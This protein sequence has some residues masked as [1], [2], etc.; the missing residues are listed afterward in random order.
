MYSL[1]SKIIQQLSR[2]IIFFDSIRF[3][4]LESFLERERRVLHIEP[5]I[6]D[7]NF[8]ICSTSIHILRTDGTTK[9]VL[10]RSYGSV[11]SSINGFVQ[12][13]TGVLIYPLW[14]AIVK[15]NRILPRGNIIIGSVTTP[16]FRDGVGTEARFWFPHSMIKI[17]E[18]D[19]ILVSD[20]KNNAIRKVD[21]VTLSVTTYLQHNS[22]DGPRG[23][24]YD[25]SYKVV[26][27]AMTSHISRLDTTKNS[28]RTVAG[29]EGTPG[30][31]NGDLVKA[32]FNQTEELA[33]VSS[34]LLLATDRGNN[35]L[36]L[37]DLGSN[38][39]QSRFGGDSQFSGIVEPTAL[40]LTRGYVFVG[41]QAGL[42][43][44]PGTISDQYEKY[45]ICSSLI[46]LL[47]L[48]HLL[49]PLYT[50]IYFN[51]SLIS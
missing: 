29:K 48:L 44:M 22:I 51:I 43:Q 34:T 9:R 1:L 41:D 21:I 45:F 28:I 50:Y 25:P 26:F 17:P 30:Y 18:E 32:R 5:D 35:I 37:I 2:N 4:Q 11:D 47:L 12:Y 27:I 19:F 46:R 38:D 36:R 10:Y 8:L 15:T 33:M 7:P 6:L 23:M 20:H 13:K 24:V 16:G 31:V 39:V 40:L 42:K 49:L 3:G 14:Y